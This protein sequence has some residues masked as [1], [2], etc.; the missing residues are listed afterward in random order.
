MQ[1]PRVKVDEDLPEDV[2]GVLGGAG[3]DAVSVREQSWTGHPDSQIWHDVQAEK[4]TLIT[5]DKGFGALA[6][7]T[8]GIG[9]WFF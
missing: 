2:V 1:L 4:R 9:G 7:A 6:R 3:F 8:G 5:A